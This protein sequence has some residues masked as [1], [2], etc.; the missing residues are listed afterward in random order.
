MEWR[1]CVFKPGV[2]PGC[3]GQRAPDSAYIC[4]RSCSR[5]ENYSTMAEDHFRTHCS[6]CEEYGAG[7][8]VQR[9]RNWAKSEAE[10]GGNTDSE[11][12]PKQVGDLLHLLLTNLN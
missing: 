6:E 8:E 12:G 2:E 5:I 11:R 4:K 10:S 9:K 7:F 3:F 1:C